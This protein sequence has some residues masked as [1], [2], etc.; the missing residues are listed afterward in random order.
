[1]KPVLKPFQRSLA[2]IIIPLGFVLCFIYGWT[3]ISTVFGLN[4]FYGNLYNYYHVSKISF[5]IYNILVAFVAG[6]ITIRLIIGVLKSNA[7]HL[8][9][10]LWIF[11]ALAVILVIGESILHLSL[12][13]DI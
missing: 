13:G 5:S 7:R 2:L 11:L 9:R 10:S 4:N 12:A 8:K 1:M 6:I 3:F